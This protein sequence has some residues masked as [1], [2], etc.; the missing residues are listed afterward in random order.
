MAKE[1]QPISQ[2]LDRFNCNDLPSEQSSPT[3]LCVSGSL[4]LPGISDLPKD[5]SCL[6]LLDLPKNEEHSWFLDLPEEIINEI[7]LCV[8]LIDRFRLSKVSKIFEKLT[9]QKRV[10]IICAKDYEEALYACDI[11]SI[12][13]YN[14][15]FPREYFLHACSIGYKEIVQLMISKFNNA[16]KYNIGLYSA[17]HSGNINII[18]LMI[19]YG[20]NDLSHG[21]YNAYEGKEIEA[22]KYLLSKGAIDENN[23]FISAIRQGHIE[24][25]KLI[26]YENTNNW[27]G[28]FDSACEYNNIE[29]V[30]MAM[31]K[32]VNWM[33]GFLNACYEG[34]IK[35][36]QLLLDND[37]IRYYDAYH[38]NDVYNLLEY[39]VYNL[40]NDGL[41]YACKIGHIKIACLLIEKGA[42]DWN[43]GFSAACEGCREHK[44]TDDYLNIM[45][46][47]ISHGAQECMHCYKSL[48]LHLTINYHSDSDDEYDSDEYD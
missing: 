1:M 46:L 29:L 16:D 37:I 40:L 43:R 32:G 28:I 45:E 44:N 18:Q 42:N 25:I 48:E 39:D 4:D 31:I 5:T 23:I 20:A 34:H 9:Y 30:Q 22:F 26:S 27:Q 47:M 6:R 21:L 36:V 13:R 12:L 10:K 14:S 19:D 8:P 38:A 35:I 24:F 41:N 2:Y 33:K 17:A 15:P 7:V 3:T 11:L